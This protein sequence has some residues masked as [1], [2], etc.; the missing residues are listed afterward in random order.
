[1]K[2]KGISLIA[3]VVTI[4]VLL[5]LAGITIGILSNNGIINKAQTAKNEYS[6]AQ[7]NETELINDAT[8]M[9]DEV[10]PG[11]KV[12]DY[13]EYT[14][15]PN[16]LSQDTINLL[17]NNSN[18]A[19]DNYVEEYNLK[20]EK[21]YWRVLD[22]KDGKMRLISDAPTKATIDL[23]G[24]KG[25][26][27]IVYLLNLVCDELYSSNFGDA[28]SLTIDDIQEH[29]SYDYTTYEINGHKYGDK[30]TIDDPL[31]KYYP[32]IY[33]NERGSNK[34]GATLN[35]SEQENIIN[36]S[37]EMQGDYTFTVSAWNKELKPD[38]FVDF[39][40]GISKYHEVLFEN[41]NSSRGYALASRFVDE[42]DELTFK[43][44]IFGVYWIHD[45]QQVSQSWMYDSKNQ[46]QELWLNFK[47]I[48]TLKEGIQIQQCQGQNSKDNMHKILNQ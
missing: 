29:L 45:N 27:N 44:A 13:I 24:Y 42:L 41:D 8:N 9:I 26:N 46:E 7:I 31:N 36:Q 12:G 5:I 4:I 16:K 2:E 34:P 10:I 23:Y 38:D 43:R 30:F 33:F 22:I 18:G 35:Q 21:L 47:P 48:V 32:E 17:Q 1:M 39:N 25:Y 15:T 11:V 20:Q 6:Q 37:K 19:I 28:K 3:L 14:P 40:N